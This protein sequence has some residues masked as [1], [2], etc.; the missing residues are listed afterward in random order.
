MPYFSPNPTDTYPV[1]Y[2]SMVNSM[3]LVSGS[4]CQSRQ[5]QIPGRTSPMLPPS[6]HHDWGPDEERVADCIGKPGG[7]G[8]GGGGL[9]LGGGDGATVTSLAT[10]IAVGFWMSIPTV[11][12]PLALSAGVPKAS[13]ATEM[14]T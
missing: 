12:N 11:T 5:N 10:L 9:G 3:V 13:K 6:L 8:E 14:L 2:D 7:G 4:S 1:V